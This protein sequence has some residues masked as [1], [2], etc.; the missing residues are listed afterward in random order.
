MNKNVGSSAVENTSARECSKARVNEKMLFLIDEINH[1]SY[2]L[3]ML[4]PK[5]YI[6]IVLGHIGII[7]LGYFFILQCQLLLQYIYNFI[8]FMNLFIYLL[9]IDKLQTK[10]RL[11]QR[12]EL[13]VNELDEL[14]K[15]KF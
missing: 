6:P 15:I 3:E 4:E 9:F 7:A 12:L 1:V 11:L 13:L 14:R 5:R 2:K 8:V 10:K